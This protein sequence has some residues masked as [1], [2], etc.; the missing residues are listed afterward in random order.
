MSRNTYYANSF[1]SFFYNIRYRKTFFERSCSRSS[2]SHLASYL[3]N[4]IVAAVKLVNAETVIPST[5]KIPSS[6]ILNANTSPAG[7]SPINCV[8]EFPSCKV[9]DP[10]LAVLLER[11]IP[12]NLV[13]PANTEPV[14]VTLTAFTSDFI[15]IFSVKI[16]VDPKVHTNYLLY[17][18]SASS[19]VYKVSTIT[20]AKR[21][22]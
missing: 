1:V 14:P 8:T 7:A 4:N 5:N 22:S 3:S 9:I 16:Y 10:A 12:L 11:I 21:S 6:G 18:C 2:I 20:E 15:F 19:N 13:L 17:Y